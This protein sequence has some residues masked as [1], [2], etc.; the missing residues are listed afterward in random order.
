MTLDYK[1]SIHPLDLATD[2]GEPGKPLIQ[3]HGR[4]V[5]ED[6][7][8]VVAALADEIGPCAELAEKL[9]GHIRVG[10]GKATQND[11]E[12]IAMYVGL[13]HQQLAK[14]TGMAE[15]MMK[16]LPPATSSPGG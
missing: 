10:A 8:I 16:R 6:L 7:A 4:N 1:K 11:V 15:V 13:I 2:I 9:W 3:H 5:G 12:L 14:L